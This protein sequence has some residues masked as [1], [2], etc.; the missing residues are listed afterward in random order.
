MSARFAVGDA[1]R[2]RPARRGGH[3]R[4]PRYL[5]SRRGRI[6]TVH[7]E[8]PLADERAEARPSVPRALYGVLFDGREVWG[9]ETEDRVTIMADL[10]E[11]YLES[12]TVE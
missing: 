11:D 5:E 12:E 3:T 9:R 6:V 10:W 8:Y 1:V 4:L 2:T 7:G